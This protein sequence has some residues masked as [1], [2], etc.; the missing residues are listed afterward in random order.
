MLWASFLSQPREPLIPAI[1]FD[2]AGLLALGTVTLLA[3]MAGVFTRR[4]VRSRQA[5]AAPEI[6]VYSLAAVVV[7]V[8]IIAALGWPDGRGWLTTGVL[9]VAT[10]ALCAG[11]ALLARRATPVQQPLAAP[12]GNGRAPFALPFAVVSSVFA[13]VVAVVA[14][15]SLR[16]FDTFAYH[17]P[18]AASWLRHSRLTT[19]VEESATFFFP[20][21]G[22]LFV[23]WMLASG[24]DRV[25]FLPAFL[26]AVGCCYAV[27]R[28][29]REIGQAREAAAV[30]GLSASSLVLLAFIATTAYIDAFM[31]LTLLLATLFLLRAR[32]SPPDDHAQAI[33][34]GTAL[35]LAIGSKYSALQPALVLGAVWLVPVIRRHW[36]P[37]EGCLR[38]LDGRAILRAVMPVAIPVV[39]C[40]A[41][42]YL[43]N[44]VQHGNPVFPFSVMGLRGL[45]NDAL[46]YVRPEVG[47]PLTWL[48]YPWREM[49]S[50][51][52]D[53]FLGGVFGGVALIGLVVAAS[54]RGAHR[55]RDLVVL[56]TIACFAL[57]LVTGNFVPRYGIFPMLLTFVFVGDLWMRYDSVVLRITTLAML[58]ITL[59]ISG[60]NLATQAVYVA[61]QGRPAYGVPQAVDTLRPARI[62]NATTSMANYYLMG[63]DYRHT[64][65]STFGDARPHDLVRFR[66]DYALLRLDDAEAFAKAA[67]LELIASSEP[68]DLTPAG[69]YRVTPRFGPPHK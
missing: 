11:T 29:A 47:T 66:P 60:R 65:I 19:N 46:I 36:R 23:R 56:I 27:Y 61:V 30:A 13:A 6:I 69:L 28:I 4:A 1:R 45:P 32:R 57:W 68:G 39:L 25:A 34:F 33:A 7:P 53:D 18:M 41:Y 62:F 5:D 2:P 35:G 3:L 43:R 63:S 49:S 54:R 21:N 8:L 55:E 52:L 31:A 44:A 48:M 37:Y 22:E 16:G 24:T 58:A 42:W 20:G 26:A 17:L 9:L 10:A 64:V 12:A 59:F 14:L 50:R 15:S 40:S 67:R 38:F 51:S